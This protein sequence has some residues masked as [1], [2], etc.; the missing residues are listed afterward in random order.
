MEE[1]G[2]FEAFIRGDEGAR[3]DIPFNLQPREKFREFMRGL[4]STFM[5]EKY[6]RIYLST[7]MKPIVEQPRVVG[8]TPTERIAVGG[9]FEI[10]E[11]AF[12]HSFV[13][14]RNLEV[15]E[16]LG[17]AILESSV[18]LFILMNWPNM[19]EAG[20][21]ANMKKFYVNNEQL[22]K[23]ADQLTF[24]RYLKRDALAGLKLKD[25]ADTFE[26]FIGALTLIGEYYIGDH[27]GEA[28][29]RTF[30]AKF[31]ALQE[32]YPDNP[33]YYDT[34]SNLYN[35]WRNALPD[36]R[37]PSYNVTYKQSADG[38][39]R[40]VVTISGKEVLDMTGSKP[41]LRG[42]GE[43][44]F[45]AAAKERA[46]A[47]IHEQLGLERATIERVR[48]SKRV[49]NPEMQRQMQILQNTFPDRKLTITRREARGGKS[50]VFIEEEIQTT[51]GS[52]TITFTET[53]ARGMGDNEAEAIRDAV[54]RITS[55]N[56][57]TPI[58]A[59]NLNLENP[60][61]APSFQKE[62]PKST[63]PQ[64]RPP[65]EPRKG[66]KFRSGTSGR[67]RGRGRGGRGSGRSGPRK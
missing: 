62:K 6:L 15:L 18:T 11:I 34:A 48:R 12:T 41:T 21:I 66:A 31:Y 39:W 51:S 55:G 19:R 47:Q 27:M 20:R 43:A 5:P 4:L 54:S 2:A 13:S 14:N 67:G 44:Q 10:L 26:S 30:L 32:W 60:D 46:L 3:P 28:I 42:T 25:K 63:T 35:D 52:M 37:K 36:D 58:Q 57:Y 1:Q 33:T 7:S 40:V 17:D 65:K 49:E 61:I 56:I 16:T 50:F 22:S 59:S 9:P 23:Y 24:P 64:F 29:A 38:V 45:K 8:K 53:R